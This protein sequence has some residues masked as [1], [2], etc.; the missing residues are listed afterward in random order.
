M[1][2][3]ELF[4]WAGSITAFEKKYFEKFCVSSQ[5]MCTSAFRTLY[6]KSETM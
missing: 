6:T 3:V 5:F 2:A 4:I 1:W